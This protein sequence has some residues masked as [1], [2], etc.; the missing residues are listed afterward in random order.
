MPPSA[1]VAQLEA[2]APGVPMYGLGC[3]RRP[4]RPRGLGH[5]IFPDKPRLRASG[6]PLAWAG[7]QLRGTSPGAQGVVSRC[8]GCALARSLPAWSPGLALAPRSSRSLPVTLPPWACH[9]W[10]SGIEQLYEVPLPGTLAQAQPT[11]SMVGL[12]TRPVRASSP[13]GPFA[14]VYAG[15]SWRHQQSRALSHDM[16]GEPAGASH[17]CAGEAR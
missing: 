3:G 8:L 11:R 6:G 7:A 14:T 15:W 4:E 17:F 9:C 10:T 12:C 13:R 16:T 2:G 1:L 5:P